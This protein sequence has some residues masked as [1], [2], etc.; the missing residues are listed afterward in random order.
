MVKEYLATLI[1]TLHRE[2]VFALILAVVNLIFLGAVGFALTE[3]GEGNFLVRLGRG[4]WWALVTLTT[5]GY[6]DVVPVTAW[7][8][9]VAADYLTPQGEP[10]ELSLTVAPVI[11][12][13]G[14]CSQILCLVEDN[15]GRTANA[16]RS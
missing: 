7:G 14:E 10:R 12:S 9:L 1:R 4:A 11:L 15:R 5:V 16:L 6:G 8:R 2:R 3:P 13:S